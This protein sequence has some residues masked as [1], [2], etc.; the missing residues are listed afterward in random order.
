MR[1][2]DGLPILV[3]GGG[4]KKTLRSVA[5]YADAWH[6]FGDVERFKR[7]IGI[8]EG[9]CAAVSRD[10]AE[11][12]FSCGPYVVIRDE[13]AEALRVLNAAL[14]PYDGSADDSEDTWVGPPERIAERWRRFAEIGVTFAIADLPAPYD[15]ETIERLPDVR[16]LLGGA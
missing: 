2:P 6:G 8:L 16:A 4:E 5:R 3:G 13:P 15:R 12:A 7:K 11:I 10:I 1:G 14:A 9:H